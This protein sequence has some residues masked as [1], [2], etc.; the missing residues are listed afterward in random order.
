MHRLKRILLVEDSELDVEMTLRAL[1][2]HRLANDV[3]VARDG[4]EALDYLLR[5]NAHAGRPEGHPV[6]ILLDNKMPRMSGLE[7]LAILRADEELARIPV[8]MLTSS[9]EEGDLVKSYELGANA[10]VV[11]PVEFQAFVAAVQELC[12][13][14]GLLNTPPPGSVR[15]P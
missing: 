12:L 3:A 2:G 6:V 5:R 11:K 8:V 9:R 1:A 4:V 10:Y 14:W 7:L 15:S 13:F